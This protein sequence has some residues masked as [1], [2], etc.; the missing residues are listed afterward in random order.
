M[1]SVRMDG[2]VF[3]ILFLINC[4]LAKHEQYI[5]YTVHGVGLR[6]QDDIAFLNQLQ[7][8][9]DLDVWSVG[10]V[11]GRDASIMVK[12][13][14]RDQFLNALDKRGLRHYVERDNVYRALEEFEENFEQWR[15]MKNNAA[16]APYNSYARYADIEAYLERLGQEYPNIV[17]VVNAGNSFEG[18][19]IKYV[20]ISTT[21]FEDRNKPI[22][23]LDA[24]MHS[25]E[26]STTPVALYTIHRLVEDLRVEDRDLLENIDWVILPVYNPDGY[27][28][29]HTDN[30]MWRRSRSYN[31]SIS[32]ECYGADLNRNFDIF[33]GQI[34][35]SSNPCSDIYPGP[36]ANS[37]IETQH[38]RDMFHQYLD[39]TQIYMNIHTYGSYVLYGFDNETLPSNAAQLHHV[40]AAMGAH[41]D[42]KKLPE[43]GYYSVGNSAFVLYAA[44][45][46]AQDYAQNIGIPFSYT[47]ELTDF[48]KYAFLVPAEYIPQINGETY[49]GIAESAR[50]SYQFYRHRLN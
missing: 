47:L 38:V 15:M 25:R 50:M 24:A 20:K 34:S 2:R 40:A 8:E 22:Y 14:L 44:S 35:V 4:V 12:P 1:G 49:A 31:A 10:M 30:R 33:F 18:R 17:T 46:T 21:N 9:L 29:S 36:Y 28:Y 7:V 43:A 41:I 16:A 37:E 13:A 23:F 45:G 19:P 3:L 39:R 11:G 42:A 26:W 27:E 48:N 6:N 32:A 5:G